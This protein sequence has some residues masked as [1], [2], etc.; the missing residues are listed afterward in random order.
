MSRAPRELARSLASEMLD[1]LA[2][3]YVEAVECDCI[4]HT[5]KDSS[6]WCGVC[7][8]SIDG[9]YAAYSY[10]AAPCFSGW[11]FVRRIEES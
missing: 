6:G 8:P 10:K 7:E 4:C 3:E 5:A 2:H 1:G 9:A 11:R